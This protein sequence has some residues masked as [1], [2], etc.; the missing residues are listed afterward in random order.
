M[1]T[2]LQQA[3]LRA[4]NPEYLTLQSR[5]LEALLSL[6]ATGVFTS[7]FSGKAAQRQVWPG[8]RVVFHEGYW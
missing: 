3:K 8:F 4:Q 2:K 6:G 1:G 7:A 5:M